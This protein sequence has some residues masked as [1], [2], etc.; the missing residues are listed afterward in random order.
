ML[1]TY[2]LNEVNENTNIKRTPKTDTTTN[3]L[4]LYAMAYKTFYSNPI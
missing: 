3:Y 1:S 4:A 2:V